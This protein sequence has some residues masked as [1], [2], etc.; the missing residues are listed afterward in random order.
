MALERCF[1]SFW[2]IVGMVFYLQEC[3]S[4]LQIGVCQ[5]DKQKYPQIQQHTAKPGCTNPTKQIR[6]R[7]AY[8]EARVTKE[9]PLL[10]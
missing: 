8:R 1:S 5:V 7:N 3:F 9:V 4:F 6:H 2:N 10:R